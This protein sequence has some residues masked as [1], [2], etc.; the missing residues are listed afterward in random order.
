MELHNIDPDVVDIIYKMS[1]INLCSNILGSITVGLMVNPPKPGDLSYDLYYQEKHGIIDSLKRRARK[2]TDTFN[3]L[4]NITC[5]ETDGAMCSFPQITLPP[6]AISA[7]ELA[8][9]EPDVFYCLELLNETGL[10]CVPGSGFQ[11]LPGTFHL[12]TTILPSEADF[13]RIADK[14]V[15][16]HKGFMKRWS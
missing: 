15:S 9:K 16:F 11:Q 2:M 12:R 1:S 5:Q 3:S 8:G 10:S 7:A 14:F 13:D 6:K 4:E